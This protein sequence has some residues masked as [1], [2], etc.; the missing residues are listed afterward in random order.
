MAKTRSDRS[1][2]SAN[3]D[4]SREVQNGLAPWPNT[5][6]L[7]GNEAT[8]AEVTHIFNQIIVTR[9]ASAW[10]G[11][12]LIRASQ[13]AILLQIGSKDLTNLLRTGSLIKGDRGPKLN[14]LLYAMEKLNGET[15]RLT[16]ALGL[17]IQTNG[18][19]DPRDQ[20]AAH[21]QFSQKHG[22]AL[23][24]GTTNGGS[25]INIKELLK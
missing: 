15:N 17:N 16:R 22:G 18:Q 14:P 9:P 2:V 11:V 13:L 8:D 1:S 20:V 25:V 21:N 19:G 10:S 12:D 24:N 5:V 4:E 3:V 6:Q 7:T 23:L